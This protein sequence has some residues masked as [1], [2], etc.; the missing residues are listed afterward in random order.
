MVT[1]VGVATIGWNPWCA[2]LLPLVALHVRLPRP[3]V[4]VANLATLPAPGPAFSCRVEVR[5]DGLLLGEDEGVLAFVGSWLH[6]AGLRTE[7]SLSRS[8][9][10][11]SHALSGL[12]LARQA[13]ARSLPATTARGPRFRGSRAEVSLSG[14]MNVAFDP[15]GAWSGTD[16]FEDAKAVQ[17]GLRGALRFWANDAP[18]VGRGEP[19]LPP[20]D[21][22]ESGVARAWREATLLWGALFAAYL[23][24][25]LIVPHSQGTTGAFGIAL[26][27]SLKRLQEARRRR[28]AERR[29]LATRGTA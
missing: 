21:V 18:P 13:V 12:A 29:A 15:C 1:L 22:H 24:L 4:A 3:E 5:C 26:L 25:G 27:P 28:K 14:A 9:I 19:V 8:D 17:T 7:F 23:V 11:A 10:T 2:L 16:Y 20:I 6:F